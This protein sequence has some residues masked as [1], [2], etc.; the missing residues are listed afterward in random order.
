MTS[1]LQLPSLKSVQDKMKGMEFN[2]EDLQIEAAKEFISHYAKSIKDRL[3]N[4]PIELQHSLGRILAEDIISPINVPPANNSAMD[5][6]AFNSAALNTSS[7]EVA[8]KVKGT[9][10]AGAFDASPI[11]DFNANE[12]CFKIMTGAAI[13][14]TCDTVIPQELIKA[15]ADSITFTRES[16]KSLANVR[17]KGEDLSQGHPALNA[18]RLLTPSD[19]GLIASLGMGQVPVKQRLKVAIFSTGNE[20]CPVGAPLKPGGIYDSNRYTLLG[21]LTRLGVEI[22]DMGV[23]KDDPN[24]LKNVLSEAASRNDVIITSGGVS[25]GQADFTK[26]VMD[27]L[28]DV[29]FWKLA[30]KPGRPMAFGKIASAGHEAILF[31][32]PGN[33]VAVMVTFYQ[34]VKTALLQMS[35]STRTDPA[36]L[37]AH[38]SGELKKRPGRTEFI[39]AKLHRDAQGT[40]WATPTANQ[41]SGILRSMSEADCLII[42]GHEQSNVPQGS[43]IDI[44]TF[45]GLI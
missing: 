35:G 31:G 6:Y 34:F 29:A 44:A 1:S 25:V 43:V 3:G 23:V 27:E 10:L 37:N 17:S 5:G 42:L 19:L 28:G 41:G 13:P 22:I 20:I 30:I 18:G 12:D 9:V 45:E 14:E 38:L 21:M 8:L 39:R 15:S 26:Q 16:I 40:L 7:N 36:L 11:S 4:E 24:A 32:L 33:P 2:S